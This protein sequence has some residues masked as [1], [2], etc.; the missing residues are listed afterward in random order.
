M[1]KIDFNNIANLNYSNKAI[2]N[3]QNE[4]N[5]NILLY[6][7]YNYKMDKMGIKQDNQKE[8]DIILKQTKEK[9]KNLSEKVGDIINNKSFSFKNYL[10]KTLYIEE[11]SQK[12]ENNI[13]SNEVELTENNKISENINFNNS[14]NIN[15]DIK[16]NSK[17]NCILKQNSGEMNIP[18]LIGKKRNQ[19]NNGK[20][21]Q[22]VEQEKKGIF[23]DILLI[24][25]EISRLNNNYIIKKQEM[26][27]ALSTDNEN[28]ETTLLINNSA[29]ATI[30]TNKDV[31]NKIFVFK[32]KTNLIKE[33][34]ILSQ[35][36]LIKKSMN[37][38]LN[39]LK[40]NNN[41]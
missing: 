14:N 30:Y 29:I 22:N 18:K 1:S 3:K 37:S 20:N 39:K 16:N 28:I 36:K 7:D 21:I 26:Q 13:I 31:I 11:A 17:L 15:L 12:E 33:N 4:Q 41:N 32:N 23:N 34:E 19:G 38:I 40:K 25:K 35:L 8:F 2:Y 6:A 9:F 10:T 24:C 5:E 27:N